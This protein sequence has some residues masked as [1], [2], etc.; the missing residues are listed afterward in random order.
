MYPTRAYGYEY[1]LV[2]NSCPYA[3]ITSS[4]VTKNTSNAGCT[5]PVERHQQQ[6]E[7]TECAYGRL[8]ML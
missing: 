7:T 1:H 8:S 5:P 3:G 2:G 4:T 6:Y